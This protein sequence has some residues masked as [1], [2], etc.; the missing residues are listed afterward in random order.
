[1]PEDLLSAIAETARAEMYKAVLRVD[2]GVRMLVNGSLHEFVPSLS[3]VIIDERHLLLRRYRTPKGFPHT[4]R[5]PV[6]IIPPLMVKPDIYDLRPGHSFVEFMLDRGFD[7]W[8]VDFGRPTA[9]DR[10]FGLGDYLLH[11]INTSVEKMREVTGSQQVSIFGYCMGGVFASVYAALE[12][13][14]AVRNVVMLGAPIDFSKL[15]LYHQLMQYVEAPMSAIAETFGYFPAFMSQ[16]MF[17]L[18]Q[19]MKAITRPVSMLWN[20]WDDDY[21]ES[22]EAMSKWMGDFLHY[23]EA[24]FKTFARDFVRDNK[25][26]RNE[27]EMFGRKVDLT[28]ITA[29]YLVLASPDDQ[30]GQPASARAI[31]DVIASEDQTFM[32]VRGGHLGAMAGSKAPA[33]WAL[34]ADWLAERSDVAEVAGSAEAA[35]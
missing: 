18:T 35:C 32:L 33:N 4:H 29:A 30:F 17:Q 13:T 12:R 19:P 15:E 25:L 3:D 11:P 31:L 34:V 14:D 9:E 26:I 10:E 1:M 5:V 8:L 16:T 24:A 2:H 28:R 27:V 7:V 21:M 20:L 23:P 6:L 22:Y